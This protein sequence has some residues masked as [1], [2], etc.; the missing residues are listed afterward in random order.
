MFTNN[1]FAIRVW[2]KGKEVSGRDKCVWRFDDCGALIRYDDYGQQ[3][4]FGWEIDH[5]IPTSKGGNDDI[6]N[7]QP[8]Q[9]ENNRAKNNSTEVTKVT[10][11]FGRNVSDRNSNILFE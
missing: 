1:G 3:S 7:L 4:E 11:K 6:S 5:I 9:W 10:A 2:A 8:L